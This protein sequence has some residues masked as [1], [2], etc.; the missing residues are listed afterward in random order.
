MPTLHAQSKQFRPSS[1]SIGR[2]SR[3]GPGCSRGTIRVW[4]QWQRQLPCSGLVLDDAED[5][6]FG[7]QAGI[8]ASLYDAHVT[9]EE[10]PPL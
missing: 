1:P 7:P 3:H 6:I 10:V 5:C 9:D 4:I 2:G 8:G